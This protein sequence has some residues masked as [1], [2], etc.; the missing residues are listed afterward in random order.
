MGFS[1]M[2]SS[3]DI[4]RDSGRR[5]ILFVLGMGRSGSSAVTRVLSLCGATLPA[6]MLG[7]NTA[8]P[9]GYWE[10]RETLLMNRKILAR[11]QSA[12]WDP[13]LRLLEDGVFSTQERA[14]HV[15]KI[16]TYLRTLPTAP[17]VV[18]KDLNIVVLHDIWFEAARSEGYDVASVIP[19][20]HPH[21]VISSLSAAART[22]PELTSALWLKGNLLAERHTRDIPRVI[23]NYANLLDDWRREIKRVAT[24]L[25]ID[26]TPPD[27]RAVDDFL[28]ADLR[29]QRDD[30]LVVDRFGRD[31]MSTVYEIMSAA[32]RDE[33]LDTAALERV[34]D[35]YRACERDF[36]RAFEQSTGWQNSLL[37]KVTR[38]SVMKP[39][40]EL[41]ALANRRS[42]SWA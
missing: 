20:R 24:G 11:H 35:E 30:S 16:R 31:W 7:A 18:L 32:A 29:R 28:A 25:S 23:V 2:T 21:E 37:N 17:V 19:M 5:V 27:E 9:R 26:L 34:Y 40:L 22:T 1:T 38:P 15:A 42:G 10:P 36:R 33:P 3:F 4:H 6:K 8:N 41:M 12:W 14:E 39:V 13:S